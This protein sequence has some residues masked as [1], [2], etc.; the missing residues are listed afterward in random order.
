MGNQ[1]IKNK[2]LKEEINYYTVL[3]SNLFDKLL[4]FS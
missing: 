4:S 1:S 3:E 2:Y